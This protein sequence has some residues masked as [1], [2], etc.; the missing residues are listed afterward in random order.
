MARGD[1]KLRRSQVITSF[2]PGA[3]ID[4]PDESVIMGGLD[5]WPESKLETVTEPRLQEAVTRALGLTKPVDLRLPPRD[6][7]MPG[8]PPVG[9]PVLA[10]PDWFV[11]DYVVKIG[12]ARSRP[13]VSRRALEKGFKYK[14]DGKSYDA[15]PVRFVQACLNGHLDDL[16][17][18]EFAH[19]G[20]TSCR[21]G[22]WLDEFGTSGDL[23]DQQVRCECGVKRALAQATK[24]SVLGVCKGRRPWLPN[25][26]R[27]GA[28][29]ANGQ[30]MR[31]LIRTASNAYYPQRLSALSLPDGVSGLRDA[32]KSVWDVLVNVGDATLLT[33]FRGAIPKVKTALEPYSDTAVLEMIEAIKGGTLPKRPP[34]KIEE[35]SALVASKD[36]MGDDR[37]D[38]DF[39]ARCLPLPS[40]VPD[41]LKGIDRVVLVHR[42]REVTSLIGFTRFEPVVPDLQGELDLEV[43]RA[44]LGT[45]I[46]WVPAMETRGEGIFI[47]FRDDAINEWR[48]RPAVQER[49]AAFRA[50]PRPGG[51]IPIDVRYVMLHSLAHLLIAAVALDCGYNASS[52]RERIYLTPQGCGILIYTGTTD[53]DGTLGG[54]VAA[55]RRVEHYLRMAL[56]LGRLCSNDPVCAQHSPSAVLEEKYALGAACHGCLLI[57]E[58]SCERRNEL[59]DRSLVVS[60]VEQLGCEFFL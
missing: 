42:L 18:Y 36:S 31:L 15:T 2:G 41:V 52:L 46:S 33:T 17:W 20:P 29:G 38:G 57:A 40:P 58:T 30:M 54:L 13:L 35:F 49:E 39:F 45:E 3:T 28:G 4:L 53:A 5:W 19:G 14:I 51:S 44:A 56:E 10:F 55:G 21:R 37:P 59:L 12:T 27:C 11:V 6:E 34:I 9:I 48:T 60:T 26:E 7:D 50:A 22:L 23:T 47:S 24:P 1:G 8:T 25:G 43:R 32:V 16:E